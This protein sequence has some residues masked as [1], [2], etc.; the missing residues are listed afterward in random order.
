MKQGDIYLV[1]LDP[2]QGREQEGQR[3]VL[4]VS[5]DEFNAA[6]RLPIVLPIT[7]GREFACRI[8]FAVPVTGIETTGIVRC[9]QPRVLDI[10]ARHGRKVDKLSSAAMDEVLAK[11]TAI[12]E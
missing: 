6:T 7:S 8:G 10:M 12:F 11:L 4:V 2:T 3:P 9:D 5:A 1:S